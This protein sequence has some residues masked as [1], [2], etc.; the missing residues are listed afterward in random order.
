MPR[1]GTPAAK[2]SSGAR[3]EPDSVV[4]SGPPESTMP[5]GAKRAMSAGSWSHAQ[6][7]Q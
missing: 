2:A 1:I 5:R 4:D 3:G 7:S 6:I